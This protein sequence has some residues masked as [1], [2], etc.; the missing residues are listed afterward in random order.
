M[1]LIQEQQKQKASLHEDHLESVKFPIYPNE[2]REFRDLLV[3]NSLNIL[4]RKSYRTFSFGCNN[5]KC[6]FPD[7]LLHL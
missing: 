7:F 1:Q 4:N 3:M 6:S 2:E 5:N